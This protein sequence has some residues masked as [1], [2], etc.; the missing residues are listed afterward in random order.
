MVAMNST[1][2]NHIRVTKL[3][4]NLDRNHDTIEHHTLRIKQNLWLTFNG[5]KRRQWPLIDW[6]S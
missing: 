4:I 5:I 6:Y 2:H 3:I 1:R